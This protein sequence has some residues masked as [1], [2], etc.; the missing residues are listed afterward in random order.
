MKT[1]ITIP[2]IIIIG[3]MLTVPGCMVLWTDHVFMYSFAKTVEMKDG[4]LVA[5]PNQT[6][7][8]S[9]QTKTE[10]DRIKGT[11]VLGG[12]PVMVETGG[13]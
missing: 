4:G 6:R 5:D 9:G 7:F 11:A 1:E 13:K 3:L 12:V 10:N 8:G 2:I